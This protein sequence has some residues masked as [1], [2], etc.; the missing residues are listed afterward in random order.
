MNV[1]T[2]HNS[3]KRTLKYV[4]RSKKINATNFA[5]N[6][7]SDLTIWPAKWANGSEYI[8]FKKKYLEKKKNRTM[9]KDEFTSI[10]LNVPQV[11]KTCLVKVIILRCPIKIDPKLSKIQFNDRSLILPSG[12]LHA[13]CISP[14]WLWKNRP[15]DF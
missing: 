14:L 13:F 2:T 8:F 15:V 6:I 1:N 4:R 11:S 12:I 9:S 7:A 10:L 3:S 5:N